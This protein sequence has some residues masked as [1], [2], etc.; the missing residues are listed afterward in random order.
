MAR[1]DKS[2]GVWSNL[3]MR[4]VLASKDSLKA[5]EKQEIIDML[6]FDSFENL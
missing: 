4:N 2:G 3:Q 5:R 1:K 6:G